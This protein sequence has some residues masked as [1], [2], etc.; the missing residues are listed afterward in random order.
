MFNWEMWLL[1]LRFMVMSRGKVAETFRPRPNVGLSNYNMIQ[2]A[3]AEARKTDWLARLSDSAK[4]NVF[5]API[6]AGEKVV[7]NKKSDL[8]EF[9]QQNWA[10]IGRR[11]HRL[12]LRK[13]LP[14]CMSV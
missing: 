2:R 12:P 1:L 10:V 5:V 6:A 14:R 9:L 7:T 4:P 3:K 13:G 11:R 8:F